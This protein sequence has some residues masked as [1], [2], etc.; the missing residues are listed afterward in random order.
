[1][2]AGPFLA[3]EMMTETVGIWIENWEKSRYFWL[4]GLE[5]TVC[6]GSFI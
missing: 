5:S 3:T 6:I 2:K 4:S 1:V